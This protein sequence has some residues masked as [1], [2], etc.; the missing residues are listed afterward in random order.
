MRDLIIAVSII[1]ISC[2]VLKIVASVIS[3]IVTAIDLRRS[4]KYSCLV[5]PNKIIVCMW[6]LWLFVGTVMLCTYSL[7][8]LT[9]NETVTAGHLIM[10]AV[11]IGVAVTG[12][13]YYYSSMVYVVDTV[14]YCSRLIFRRKVSIS[15][16]YADLDEKENIRIFYNGGKKF[17]TI[18]GTSEGYDAA[19]EVLKSY[20]VMNKRKVR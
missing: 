4:K 1:A 12:I 16:V 17:A 10:C 7:F 20:G 9:G 15:E 6:M 13:L 14:I 19:T 3:F 18:S 8:Y 11:M 5:T 2:V